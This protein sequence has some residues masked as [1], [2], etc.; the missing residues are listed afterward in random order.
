MTVARLAIACLLLTMA[1]C[2][3]TPPAT[4]VKATTPTT[5]TP[6]NDCGGAVPALAE[7]LS[8]RRDVTNVEVIGQCTLARIS[9]TLTKST[10]GSAVAKEL[11]EA[12]GHVAYATPGVSSVSVKSTTGEELAVG[13]KGAPCLMSP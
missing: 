8:G 6:V 2:G 7:R 1:G 5:T 10:D 11:C 3:S 12:A 13:I 9:T 4:P